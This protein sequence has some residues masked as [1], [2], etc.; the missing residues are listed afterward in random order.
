MYVTCK[1]KNLNESGY[2]V[3][4][5]RKF[6]QVFFWEKDFKTLNIYTNAVLGSEEYG[7]R[8]IL[9]NSFNLEYSFC[10]NDDQNNNVL[11]FDTKSI[12][13]S[14]FLFSDPN[15]W[16]TVWGEDTTV[17]KSN[18]DFNHAYEALFKIK[19]NLASNAVDQYLL[20]K[21]PA[22][23]DL[24]SNTIG[25][26][27]NS[28]P[29]DLFNRF[30]INP[31]EEI[32]RYI[33]IVNLT[34]TTIIFTERQST[35]L[36]YLIEFEES[37]KF[38]FNDNSIYFVLPDSFDIKDSNASIYNK[39]DSDPKEQDDN[40]F[41][42]LDPDSKK[43]VRE[44][45]NKGIEER[46]YWR[47]KNT[48]FKSF[49]YTEKYHKLHFNF[50]IISSINPVIRQLIVGFL[51]SLFF[52]YGLDQ[53]RLLNYRDLF[54]FYNIIP[55]GVNFFITY[56][57]LFI[58]ILFKISLGNNFERKPAAISR[59][60]A[61]TFSILWFVCLYIFPNPQSFYSS[62]SMLC[63]S[64]FTQYGIIASNILNGLALGANLTS[65]LL[66]KCY[67]KDEI[68]IALLEQIIKLFRL[69]K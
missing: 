46:K 65:V 27:V 32:F 55:P 28:I 29:D 16:K 52:T 7:Q 47:I 26:I 37:Q 3:I 69:T 62:D 20:I 58:A 63:P 36:N 8:K 60:I 5:F 22:K 6:Y 35:L 48:K 42:K 38:T 30:R 23:T 25:K 50:R 57:L 59:I 56:S 18:D 21:N 12:D 14:S 11:L 2:P 54:G 41:Q 43:Y 15:A 51:I 10:C 61:I 31:P 19:S 67:H 68:N 9:N 39:Q 66:I 13:K 40:S 49:D 24:I 45:I 4:T 44:W 1:I 64:G 17:I 53:T 33:E 34:L